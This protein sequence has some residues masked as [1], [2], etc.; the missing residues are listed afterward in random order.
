MLL[1]DEDPDAPVRSFHVWSPEFLKQFL[2]ML[3]PFGFRCHEDMIMA[4]PS[5]DWTIERTK[6]TAYAY[7]RF[8]DRPEL[9]NPCFTIFFRGRLVASIRV[10]VYRYSTSYSVQWN[11]TLIPRIRDYLTMRQMDH[12]FPEFMPSI[13]EPFLIG[14]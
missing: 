10:T 11:D 13:L 5:V 6:G 7:H 12:R 14:S 9:Y 8:T 1:S 4:P 2:E 3:E